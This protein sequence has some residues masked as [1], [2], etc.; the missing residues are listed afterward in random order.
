MKT[1]NQNL[2]F[3]HLA[4]FQ[5]YPVGTV[6]FAVTGKHFVGAFAQMIFPEKFSDGGFLCGDEVQKGAVHIP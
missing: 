5:F 3:G 1:A 2:R 6:N 4:V